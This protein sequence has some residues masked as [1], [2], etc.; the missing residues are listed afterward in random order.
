MRAQLLLLAGGVIG[1]LGLGWVTAPAPEADAAASLDTPAV[2][3]AGVAAADARTRLAALGLAPPPVVDAGPPPPDVAVLFRRDLTAIEER[4]AQRVV[5]IVDYAQTHQRRALRV[6]DIYQDG[7]RVARIGAQR[8]ELRR[9]RE[10]RTVDA[11]A[12]PVIE[13]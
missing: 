13:P 1:G 6:G 3:H 11:F 12:L 5:W 2:V 4:G 7:W 10:V 8:V 9:R